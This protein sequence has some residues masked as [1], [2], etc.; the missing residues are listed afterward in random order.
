MY[1]ELYHPH[2]SRRTTTKFGVK[3]E[4]ALSGFGR[5]DKSYR[6]AVPIPMD[7]T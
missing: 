1:S 3:K 6:D 7:P 4:L 5:P 2:P